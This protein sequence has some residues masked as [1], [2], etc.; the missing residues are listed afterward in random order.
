MLCGLE[1]WAG[2][3]PGAVEVLPLPALVIA[4]QPA[5]AHTQG[6][7][8]VGG[9][10]Y[11]TARREDARPKQALLLRTGADRPGWDVWDITP[12]AT[13]RPADAAALLDHPGGFQAGGGKLWIPLA[14]SRRNGRS[15]IRAYALADLQPGKPA[16]AV[17]EFPVD[18]HV[19]AIAVA[20]RDGLLMGASWDTETVYAWDF[21]GRLRRTLSG[22][23]LA[24]WGLGVAAGP[25]GRP[26]VAVQDWK[27]AG[28]RVIA[29][30]LGRASGAAASDSESCLV[31]FPV[32][33]AAGFPARRIRLPA[34]EGA[35][36]AREG[37]AL[38][39]GLVCFLPD[40]LGATNRLYRLPLAAIGL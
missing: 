17:F 25:D 38:V 3:P 26:G 18:D 27:V 11:V 9:T 35:G 34:P 24:A 14:Q 29:S 15:L 30:G 33:F 8:V 32:S 31:S 40:D 6:L 19:G 36:L 10:Y 21:Q 12:V 37:M 28:P 5:R 1:G 4:G 39:D 7:E 2:A 23:E 22:T 20:A 16:R 13:D